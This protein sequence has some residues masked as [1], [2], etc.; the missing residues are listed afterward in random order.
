MDD[1]KIQQLIFAQRPVPRQG[2]DLR[3]DRE[4]RLLAG[5]AP[6]M[7]KK[8]SILAVAVAVILSLVMFGAVAELLGANLFELFGKNDKRIEQLAPKAVLEET[9]P[10][11]NTSPELGTTTALINSAYYDGQSLIVAFGIENGEYYEAFTPTSAQLS[12]ME[13][14]N[15]PLAIVITNPQ[16]QDI[17]RQWNE[18]TAAGKPFGYAQLSV[19]PSDHTKTP[20]GLDLPPEMSEDLIGP[21]GQVYT[22]IHYLSPLPEAARDLDALP[23]EI[24]LHKSVQYHYFDGKDAFISAE[25]ERLEPMK[26][27]IQRTD[28]GTRRFTGQGTFAGIPFTAKVSA[29]AVFAQATLTSDGPPF[30]PLPEDAW[31]SLYLRDGSQTSFRALGGPED[32]KDTLVVSFHGIGKTP[33]SLEMQLRV[34]SEEGVVLDEQLTQPAFIELTEDK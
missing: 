30:P 13:K 22:I 23:I 8:I 5:E 31:Y 26:A 28:A 20:E 27:T 4:A 24:G 19:T 14:T 32:G 1:K 16:T 18:A 21:D 3:I 11:T 25:H 34:D 9:S 7:K 12:A 29:S 15:N 10:I 33:E 2:F 6:M 17:L